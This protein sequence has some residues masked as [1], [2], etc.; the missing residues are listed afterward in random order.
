MAACPKCGRA[1]VRRHSV[2]KYRVCRRCGVL[3]GV[4]HCDQGGAPHE[5]RDALAAS[6]NHPMA[7]EKPASPFG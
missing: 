5:T 2:H 4:R 3:P 6:Q 7:V 1:K